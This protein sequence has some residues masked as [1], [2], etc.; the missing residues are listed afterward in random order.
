[1][2]IFSYEA[3]LFQDFDDYDLFAQNFNK[4][5]KSI[6]QNEYKNYIAEKLIEINSFSFF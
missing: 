4:F 6:S 5:K 2:K 1:M 3:D